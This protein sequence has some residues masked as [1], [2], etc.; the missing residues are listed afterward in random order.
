[1]AELSQHVDLISELRQQLLSDVWIED[2]L[3]CDGE[4]FVFTLVDHTEPTLR[5]LFTQL[6]VLEV[7]LQHGVGIQP[8]RM[9][10]G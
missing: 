8:H 10:L 7:D 6:Q 4:P 9:L 3:D 5:Y 1:M 2:L